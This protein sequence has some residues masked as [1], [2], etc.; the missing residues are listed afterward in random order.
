MTQYFE[1]ILNRKLWLIEPPLPFS[2]RHLQYQSNIST[3]TIFIIFLEFSMIFSIN[4]KYI[5]IVFDR[6]IYFLLFIVVYWYFALL[7]VDSIVKKQF[8]NKLNNLHC[9]LSLFFSK[10][11]LNQI[12][13]NRKSRRVQLTNLLSLCVSYS[14]FWWMSEPSKRGGK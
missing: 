8:H 3:Q 2:I 4:F 5:P 11:I 6:F 1:Y 13:E 7:F 14:Y 10:R 12:Q 9:T